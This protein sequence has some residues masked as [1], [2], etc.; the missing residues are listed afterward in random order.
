M[1]VGSGEDSINHFRTVTWGNIG[2]TKSNI[3]TGELDI[4]KVFG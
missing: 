2:Q 1:S 4:Y 3:P